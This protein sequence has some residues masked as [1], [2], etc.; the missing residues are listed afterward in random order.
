M[1]DSD[2]KAVIISQEDELGSNAEQDGVLNCQLFYFYICIFLFGGTNCLGET[3][4]VV[5]HVVH[6]V[7]VTE[8]GV[9]DDPKW[10]SWCWNI[11]S[12]E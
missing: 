10:T 7:V 2:G 4:T 11:D 12:H 9:S 8:E 6:G 5:L 1:L 3:D